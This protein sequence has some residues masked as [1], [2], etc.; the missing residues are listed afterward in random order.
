MIVL[1]WWAADNGIF[2]SNDCFWHKACLA[3]NLHI[4]GW[5]NTWKTVEC[6]PCCIH[7]RFVH[8]AYLERTNRSALGPL[9]HTTLKMI[10]QMACI[11]E[12][13]WESERLH[14]DLAKRVSQCLPSL[15]V[16]PGQESNDNCKNCDFLRIW[17]HD[18]KF[19]MS[20]AH[21][22]WG[23]INRG[24]VLG[25]VPLL[26]RIGVHSTFIPFTNMDRSGGHIHKL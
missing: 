20:D 26:Y 24:I 17:K 7:T 19:H 6:Q 13:L 23:H 15:V 21:S 12:W 18:T 22:S 10:F 4:N 5:V 16:R 8:L 2:S 1:P 25:G 11:L 9:C 14:D 3:H